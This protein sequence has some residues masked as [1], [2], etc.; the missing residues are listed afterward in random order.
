MNTSES[1][2]N[3]PAQSDVSRRSFIKQGAVGVAGLAAVSAVAQSSAIK[4]V[5]PASV[6]GANERIRTGHIGTGGMGMRNLQFCVFREAKD[7]Q[8]IAVCDLREEAREQAADLV[9]NAYDRPTTHER[10]E[11]I[12]ENK[13]VDAVVIVTPDHWHT[14]P[15]MM[16]CDAGKDVWCE[17]PLTTTIAEG[18]PLIDAVRRNKRVLQ[19]GNFQRSGVHFQEVRDLVREGYIGKIARVET[20][21]HD[22][23]AQHDIGSPPDEA[24]PPG[25]DWD[26][27]IGWTDKVPFNKNRFVYNFRWFLDY[28]GGKMTDWGAHLIDIVL[29]AMGEDKAPK[30]VTAMGGKYV[31]QDNRTTPDQLDV[32]YDFGDYVLS[33][34]NRVY[35]GYVER[36][37]YGIMFYGEKGTLYADRLGYFV[38]PVEDRCEAREVKDQKEGDMNVAHWDNFVECV[39]SRKDPISSVESAFNTALVCHIGTTAYVSGGKLDWDSS[40]M[41]FKGADADA[42]KK[43]NDWAYRPYQNGWMLKAP[44]NEGWKA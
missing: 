36:N 41:K 40:A 7:V 25:V 31:L 35:N 21:I 8:P 37:R 12:I 44:Y 2:S 5:F 27:Y 1:K 28:S 6:L 39:K 4:H 34:S 24:P 33:F 32:L 43:A 29:W 9:T 22:G 38:T 11:E 3:D 14:I 13:D 42:V 30:S 26:R 19:C 18:Q 17:K 23:G 20:W 16:A 10:F 15:S